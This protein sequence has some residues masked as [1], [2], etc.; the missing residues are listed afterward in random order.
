MARKPKPPQRAR[1]RD[2]DKPII[3]SYGRRGRANRDFVTARVA[4]NRRRFRIALITVAV[5]AIVGSVGTWWMFNQSVGFAVTALPA[6]ARLIVAE[7]PEGAS[8]P[9]ECTGTICATD[10]AVGT[11]RVNVSRTGFATQTVTV[12]ARRFSANEM[13]VVLEALP[14]AITVTAKPSSAKISITGPQGISIAEGT[15]KVSATAAAGTV[16]VSVS[17]SGKNTFSRELMLD[18]PTTLAVSLDPKGQLV[19]GLGMIT[20]HGAPKGVAITPDG[21][22]AWA[23]ILNGPPSIEIFEPRS[24]KRLGTVDLGKYGAVEIIFNR[25]GTRAYASQMETAKVF[26]LDTKTHKVLRSF[27]TQSS[28]TKVI[29][30]SPDEGT[31][32]AA[33]WSGNDVSVIDLGNG[34]L[35]RR[36]PVAKTPRGLWPTADGKS[37]YVASFDRGVLQKADVA[38]GKV[39]TVF[40]DGGALRHLVGDEKRGLLF[41]SDM[42]KDCVWVTDM[43]TGATKR[44]A[45]VG[46]KPNTI[47]LSPDGKVLFVSNR[48]ENNAKSYY[49]PGPEWGSIMLLDT[50][51]GKLLDG[52]VGGNQ[53]TALAV[54][55]D[56]KLLVFSDF[57]D[58]RLRVYETPGYETLIAGKGGRSGTLAK[59]VRK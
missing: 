34:K 26:E 58:N 10:T 29:A 50:H 27:A 28:W 57:L 53:C 20:T 5:V 43:K 8:V 21:S 55:R 17:A 13:K 52:I 51:T 44:F 48:G 39:K 41:A 47:E 32:Y 12:D 9:G 31:L 19:H 16:K 45:K 15:G 59:D 38:T 42:A 14:Q 56:G 7:S 2:I 37:L 23:T 33:N 3:T 6:D 1:L 40:S 18:R 4:R 11:Y 30:L 24:G 25:A 46:H 22:Q 36:I 54:S 35:T 49:I